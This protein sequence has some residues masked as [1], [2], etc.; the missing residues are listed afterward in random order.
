MSEKPLN[1]KE[2]RAVREIIAAHE[3]RKKAF[4]RQV[5]LEEELSQIPTSGDGYGSG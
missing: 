3:S 5:Q 1:D 4:L 2:I